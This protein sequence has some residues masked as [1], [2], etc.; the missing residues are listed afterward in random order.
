MEEFVGDAIKIAIANRQLFSW[1]HVQNAH[2][3]TTN[4]WKAKNISSTSSSDRL[5]TK[6]KS[7]LEY[8]DND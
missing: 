7:D 4:D 2:D 8:I 5:D 6:L 1:H 3:V